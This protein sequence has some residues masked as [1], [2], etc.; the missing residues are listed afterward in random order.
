MDSMSITRNVTHVEDW[1]YYLQMLCGYQYIERVYFTLFFLLLPHPLP[2]SN[3]IQYPLTHMII[4]WG[5]RF[6]VARQKFECI[7]SLKVL[8]TCLHLVA[9]YAG[10]VPLGYHQLW[11]FDFLLYSPVC[12]MLIIINTFLSPSQPL[13]TSPVCFTSSLYSQIII[14]PIIQI[15]KPETRRDDWLTEQVPCCGTD[16]TAGA[17]L[18]YVPACRLDDENG[19]LEPARGFQ[20][21][22][23]RIPMTR[24]E[25][26]RMALNVQLNSHPLLTNKFASKHIVI[27]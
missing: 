17:S 11:G 9:Y 20:G 23:K 3:T 5:E 1:F 15:H 22:R 24:N 8:H 10:L 4:L 19:V 14:F 18:V 6:S 12:T 7:V 25:N 13:T 27:Q 2:C 16:I 26:T 21:T